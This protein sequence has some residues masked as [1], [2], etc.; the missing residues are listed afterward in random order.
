M[1]ALNRYDLDKYSL[2]AIDKLLHFTL[3]PMT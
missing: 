2:D 3:Q 1:T